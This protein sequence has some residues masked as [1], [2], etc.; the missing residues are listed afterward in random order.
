[1]TPENLDLSAPL[2]AVVNLP[3]SHRRQTEFITNYLSFNFLIAESANFIVSVSV[4]FLD[5]ITLYIIQ[6][7][8][9]INPV[10]DQLTVQLVT[11]I[12]K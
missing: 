4:F 6:I 12:A 11:L 9:R 10:L 2:F 3:D 5:Q 7:D 1:L 8:A